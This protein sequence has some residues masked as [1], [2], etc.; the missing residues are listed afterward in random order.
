MAVIAK[1]NGDSDQPSESVIELA[2]VRAVIDNRLTTYRTGVVAGI[3]F[4]IASFF[5]PTVPS[6]LLGVCASVVTVLW[7][8]ANVLTQQ[9]L[10]AKAARLLTSG[11]RPEA[12]R[13]RFYKLPQIRGAL[14]GVL[15]FIDRDEHRF[16]DGAVGL[17]RLIGE[18]DVHLLEDESA[19]GFV[20]M[21]TPNGSVLLFLQP[22]CP[23]PPPVDELESC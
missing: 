6:M 12:A 15:F 3:A 5:A 2:D 9:G 1:L 7:S 14:P 18:Q 23:G 19:P 11:C 10:L 17:H 8:G 16:I 21:K 13:V 22:S 20:L 4:L